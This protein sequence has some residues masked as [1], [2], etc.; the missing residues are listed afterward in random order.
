MVLLEFW[1]QVYVSSLSGAAVVGAMTTKNL[2]ASAEEIADQ[3]LERL[4]TK[5]GNE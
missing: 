1:I 4:R 3:A 2:V 5:V